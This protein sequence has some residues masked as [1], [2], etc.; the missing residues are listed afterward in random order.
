MDEHVNSGGQKYDILIE[1]LPITDHQGIPEA[2]DTGLKIARYSVSGVMKDIISKV[3]KVIYRR[4]TPN[5]IQ[6]PSMNSR[7]DKLKE[8]NTVKGC[9][10]SS[11]KEVR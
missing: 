9:S 5:S 1:G 2:T 6:T 8:I 11:P 10:L 4:Y 3:K 7:A